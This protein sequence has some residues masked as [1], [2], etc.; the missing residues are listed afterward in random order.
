MTTMAGCS[1]D[2]LDTL[3][4]EPRVFQS[5]TSSKQNRSN[6]LCESVEPPQLVGCQSQVFSSAAVPSYKKK[7]LNNMETLA[8]S[9]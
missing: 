1:D 7:L 9:G 3:I 6:P 5:E 4:G 2:S 8:K